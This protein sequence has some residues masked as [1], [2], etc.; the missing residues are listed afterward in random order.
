MANPFTVNV[1]LRCFQSGYFPLKMH[2]TDVGSED[3]VN[4]WFAYYFGDAKVLHP[5][6]MTCGAPREILNKAA[7]IG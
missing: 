2:W 3:L 7:A 1:W 5:S 6:R 4:Q